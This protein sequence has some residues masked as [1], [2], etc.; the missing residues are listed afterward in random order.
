MHSPVREVAPR[1]EGPNLGQSV[2]RS[3][4]VI[5]A[6]MCAY[7][8]ARPSD[9]R[10]STVQASAARTVCVSGGCQPQAELAIGRGTCRCASGSTSDALES[11]SFTPKRSLVRS[12]Y[13]P[14]S[15]YAGQKPVAVR[16]GNGILAICPLHWEQIGSSPLPATSSERLVAWS[17]PAS[18]RSREGSNF[19][20]GRSSAGPSPEPARRCIEPG[21]QSCGDGVIPTPRDCVSGR[22]IV[23]VARKPS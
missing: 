3:I 9:T 10:R 22:S 7:G 18:P 4:Q 8:S 13:R 17:T 2:G 6:G 14:P 11:T 19:G 21:E 12:Q 5:Q 23:P 16:S 15:I 1:A 20:R